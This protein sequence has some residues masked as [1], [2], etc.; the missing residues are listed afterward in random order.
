M[1][2]YEMRISDWSSDVCSSDLERR[3]VN[4][5]FNTRLVHNFVYFI[6]AYIYFHSAARLVQHLPVSAH[7]QTRIFKPPLIVYYTHACITSQSCLLASLFQCPARF[8]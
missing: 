7:R 5:S 1:S 2:A 3:G 6:R 8:F 4:A